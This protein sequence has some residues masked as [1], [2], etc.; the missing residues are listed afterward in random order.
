[1]NFADLM[2]WASTVPLEELQ[3]ARDDAFARACRESFATFARRAWEEIDPAPLVWNWHLDAICTHLQAVTEGRIKRLLIN[4]PPGH[5]KSM[6]VAVLWPAWVWL[7]HPGWRALFASYAKELS[8][9]DA[10]KCRTLIES[11]WY[12]DLRERVC[13]QFGL[14]LW[15][16][17]DDANQVGYYANTALGERKAIGVEGQGTGYRGDCIVVDDPLKAQDVTSEAARVSVLEWWTGTMTSRLNDLESGAVVMIMQ[18]LHEQDLAAHVLAGGGYDHLCLPTEFECVRPC[19]CATC[20]KGKTSIGWEDPRKTDGD[21]LFPKKFGPAAIAAAK[22]PTQGMGPVAFAAQHQQRPVPAGGHMLKEV[23][24]RRVWRTVGE[25]EH[26]SGSYEQGLEVR[27]IEDPQK[28][29][30]DQVV[31]SV[32]CSFKKTD[33]ADRVAVEV[34]ARKGP[35]LYLLDLAWDRMG[36]IETMQAIKDLAKKW[37]RCT[38]KMIEDKANG[39]A[40]IELLRAQISGILPVEPQ[41][42][43]EARIAAASPFIEAGNVWL[44][45][46][47]PWRK[48]FVAEACAFPAGAH[49]DAVDCMAYAVT[50]LGTRA[51]AHAFRASLLKQAVARQ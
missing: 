31:M 8:L 34:W 6:F 2:Q 26:A 47:A 11:A 21:L 20:Q 37:P 4:V 16:F 32:D 46:H 38:L 23:W 49:D 14:Q 25:P 17:T 51:G 5:A 18:R 1:M 45:L 27:T 22:H 12:R 44:P 9:R 41:G 19:A 40:V 42:G 30:W 13:R 3:A 33:D 10:R 29:K 36:I 50:R 43:K 39:S 28:A 7:R 15:G 48:A 24:F 35:D